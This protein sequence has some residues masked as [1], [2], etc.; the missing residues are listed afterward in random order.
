MTAI[1]DNTYITSSRQLAAG[2]EC[3]GQK[4]VTNGGVMNQY[5]DFAGLSGDYRY[6]L[7]LQ[8][9]A[10]GAK[11]AYLYLNGDENT[12]HYYNER[13]YAD[14]AIIASA[15]SNTSAIFT[16]WAAGGLYSECEIAI[17]DSDYATFVSRMNSPNT[18]LMVLNY[19]AG[20]KTDATMT[21]IT[22]IKI[23]ALSL[24]NGYTGTVTLYR[25]SAR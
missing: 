18:N 24:N 2:W 7:F 12:A 23:K 16:T 15:R 25:A 9:Y 1:I 13:L 22:E 17:D 11:T 3:V 4:S 19:Y 10:N 14:D 20:G 8:G 6:K 5:W 21:E